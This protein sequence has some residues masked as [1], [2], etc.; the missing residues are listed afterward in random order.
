MRKPSMQSGSAREQRK[1][2]GSS[3]VEQGRAGEQGRVQGRATE[4]CGKAAEQGRAA[5]HSKKIQDH[6]GCQNL[7]SNLSRVSENKKC[8]TMQIV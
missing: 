5:G 6:C 4:Q 2:A 7:P 8:K 1:A 3:A